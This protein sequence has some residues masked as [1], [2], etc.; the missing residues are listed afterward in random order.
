MTKIESEILQ[1]QSFSS[2]GLHAYV[3]WIGLL[4]TVLLDFDL[5]MEYRLDQ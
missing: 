1:G 3:K 4:P 5:S 2:N